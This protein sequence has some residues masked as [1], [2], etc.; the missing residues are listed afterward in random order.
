MR[1]TFQRWRPRRSLDSFFGRAMRGMMPLRRQAERFL[2]QVHTYDLTGTFSNERRT[3]RQ[4]LKENA[5]QRIDIRL[6]IDAASSSA[7]F[8]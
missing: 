3:T 5:T 7:L 4:H 8:R 1:S 6:F 2:E